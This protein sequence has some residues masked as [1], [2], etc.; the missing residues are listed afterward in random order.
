MI[1][2]KEVFEIRNIEG[3]KVKTLVE[4]HLIEDNKYEWNWKKDYG[5]P[6][7]SLSEM[8]LIAD[9]FL[10]ICNEKRGQQTEL[11]GISEG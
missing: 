9:A 7:L 1:S 6:K 8:R 11:P 5:N 2:K 10:E 4:L 3:D